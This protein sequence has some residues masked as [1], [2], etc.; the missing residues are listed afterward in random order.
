M[1]LLLQ[2]W[3]VPTAKFGNKERWE[4]N[5]T[6]L[7]NST[8]TGQ[9]L[10]VVFLD[11]MGRLYGTC[12]GNPHHKAHQFPAQMLLSAK[13]SYHLKYQWEWRG[14]VA[15]GH[16]W[17]QAENFQWELKGGL[18]QCKFFDECY[19]LNGLIAAQHGQTLLYHFIDEQRKTN[20]TF[21]VDTSRQF[22]GVLHDN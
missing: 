18:I 10:H 9:E 2:G 5:R 13:A 17:Y 3:S 15:K 8:P 11:H 14:N 12:N 6:M 19:D 4:T 22:G 20:S 16:I 7:N 21:G 1:Q